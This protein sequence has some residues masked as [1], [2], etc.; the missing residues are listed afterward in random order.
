MTVPYH[1]VVYDASVTPVRFLV[2]RVTNEGDNTTTYDATLLA[3][4][5][6]ASTA[7]SIRDRLNQA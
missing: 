1:A 2:I 3:E 5:T 6:N 7:R 4:C